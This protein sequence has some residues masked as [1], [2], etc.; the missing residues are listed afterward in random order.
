[1]MIYLQ[2]FSAGNNRLS[3]SLPKE[4]YY[5]ASLTKLS[6]DNNSFTGSVLSNVG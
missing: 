3:G 6:L 5:L 1:M 4:I 2:Q